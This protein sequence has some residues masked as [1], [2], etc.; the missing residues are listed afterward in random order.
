M[1]LP[2]YAVTTQRLFARGAFDDPG[3]R[4]ISPRRA[5]LPRRPM[6][7]LQLPLPLSH[8]AADHAQGDA[9]NVEGAAHRTTPE[10]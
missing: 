3:P 6:R 2:P 1:T 10:A 7:P 9:S 4:S 8:E 5:E